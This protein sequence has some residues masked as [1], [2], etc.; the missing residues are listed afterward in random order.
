MCLDEGEL[1]VKALAQCDTGANFYLN[2]SPVSDSANKENDLSSLTIDGKEIAAENG[3]YSCTVPYTAN[4]VTLVAA[5]QDPKG[6]ITLDGKV[7]GSS[8]SKTLLLN[9]KE[10]EYEICVYS[11][12]Q[13]SKKTYTLKINK[14]F[15][16]YELS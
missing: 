5:A 16:N 15:T 11:E 7:L 13:T 8:S 6:I 14:D 2:E 9:G 4:T 3:V 10:T 1:V 12:D